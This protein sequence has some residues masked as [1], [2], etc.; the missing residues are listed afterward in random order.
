[1]L[2]TSSNVVF[3][4]LSVTQ[5]LLF[6]MGHAVVQLIEALHFK[7]K[8]HGFGFRWCHYSRTMVLGSTQPVT[9]MSTRNISWKAGGVK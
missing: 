6:V 2:A 8:R 9:E 4:K 5:L 1:M 7:L 3:E